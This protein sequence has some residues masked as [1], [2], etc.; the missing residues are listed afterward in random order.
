[1]QLSY[2][3]MQLEGYGPHAGKY[4]GSMMFKDQ[5]GGIEI[6]LDTSLSHAV[7]KLCADALVENAKKS[8][9]MMAGNILE[10]A[11]QPKALE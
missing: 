5:S 7:L 10:Q 8:A 1:M 4:K 3:S 9:Q 2:L 11:A 6:V